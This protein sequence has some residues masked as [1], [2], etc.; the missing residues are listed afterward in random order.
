MAELNITLT[1]SQH[2]IIDCKASEIWYG[3]A[4]GGGKSAALRRIAVLLCTEIPNFQ[5]FLFRRKRPDLIRT[6]L[7]GPDSFR[8]ILKP[9][10]DDGLVKIVKDEIRWWH[11]S[12][13][14]FC[15]C[16]HEDDVDNYLS[17]EM[18]GLGI[19]EVSAFTPQMYRKLRART[20]V[21]GLD[22][23]D[24]WKGR[25]PFILLASNPGG[26]CHDYLKEAF[27]DPHPQGGVEFRAPADDGSK[28]RIFLPS[29]VDDNPHLDAEEYKR[30]LEGL[31]S[32][33]LVRMY[34]DG[35]MNVIL[36]SFF[37]IFGMRHIIRPFT[38]PTWWMR[39]RAMDWGM[40]HPHV[41][42]WFAVSDGSIEGI[43]EGALVVYREQVKG[44]M[45]AKDAGEL[46]VQNT[47]SDENIRY[48]VLDPAACNKRSETEKDKTIS[49]ELHK[50][51]VYCIPADN[52]RVPGWNQVYTRFTDDMLF[53]FDTC[54]QLIKCIPKAKH[55]DKDVDDVA[56]FNG[57]DPLDTLR[58]GCMSHMY[59]KK[60]KVK[61]KPIKGFSDYNYN[62]LHRS[63]EAQ[64]E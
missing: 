5:F 29:R 3:G 52:D 44:D 27:Y 13:L 32:D 64:H 14:H 57:D 35:D 59:I 2:R 54:Q 22:I 41:C 63:I 33:E 25:I 11:G 15:H 8:I 55:H 62:D 23:P 34:R 31:G 53:I 30:T 10:I 38:I 49:Q 28:L 16:Q 12:T 6:H 36:G 37:K 26:E 48:T 39:F 18:H 19:D 24:E 47:K 4:A 61:S 9:L 17:S 40:N 43:D 42:L 45:V 21:A 50:G 46:V 60:E 51:G 1:P 56:K 58:Y 7:R 20:R